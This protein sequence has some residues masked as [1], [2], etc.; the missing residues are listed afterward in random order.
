MVIKRKENWFFIFYDLEGR[1]SFAYVP[2]RDQNLVV[3]GK[4]WRLIGFVF[5]ISFEKG[6]KMKRPIGKISL[7][8]FFIFKGK[9][10]K[11]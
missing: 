7:F 9:W 10:L 11:V 6:F 2:V 8:V 3:R 4:N 5:F 1:A